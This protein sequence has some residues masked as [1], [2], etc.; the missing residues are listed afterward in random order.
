MKKFLSAILALGCM[1]ASAIG[2]AA[3]DPGSSNPPPTGTINYT[4]TVEGLEDDPVTLATVQVTLMQGDTEMTEATALEGNVA[5]FS[6]APDTYSVKLTGALSQF[7]WTET[8]VTATAPNAKITLTE[9]G[10]SDPGETTI[11]YTL[12][13]QLPD[14]TPVEGV[15]VQLC[16]GPSGNCFPK[17]TDANGVAEFDLAAGEYEVHIEDTLPSGYTF[18]NTKY[19]MSAQGGAL[20]VTL[21]A[22]PE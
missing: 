11:R 12:T 3:C 15:I 14:G 9:K 6:L 2:F 21:T 17:T 20:T 22:L 7:E 10:G 18:D 19:T 5:T 16:G 1:A 13:L 4:V 8:F